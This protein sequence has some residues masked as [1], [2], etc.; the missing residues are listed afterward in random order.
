MLI[1][2]VDVIIRNV[3]HISED[4]VL[5]YIALLTNEHGGIRPRKLIDIVNIG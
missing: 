4:E 3:P 2:G 1:N 5:E